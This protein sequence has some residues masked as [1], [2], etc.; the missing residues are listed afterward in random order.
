MDIA[1]RAPSRAKKTVAAGAVAAVA[2]LGLGATAWRST[3][4]ALPSIDKSTVW[5]ERVRRGDLVRQVPVQGTLVPER[6]QWLSAVT[7][8]RVAHIE[9]RPGAVVEADSVVMVLENAELELAALVAEQQAASAETALVQLD[10]RTLAD[11]K[12][13]EGVVAGARMDARDADAHAMA[14]DRLAP[15]GLLGAI[16]HDAAQNRAKGLNE[17]LLTEDARRAVLE[18]GRGRQLTA[19]RAEVERLREIAKFRKKQLADLVIRAGVKGVVQDVPLENGQWVA[20]GALL[21]KVAEPD[22]LKADVRVAEGNAREVLKGQAVRFE[23]PAGS[24][25]G[26]IARV[27]PAVV[28][29]NVRLEVALDEPLPA[30]ARADQ[31]VTGYVEIETLH[32]ALFVPRP[33]AAQDGAPAGVFVLDADR[34]TATRRT[35]RLGRGSARDV[36]I[37]GGL[38][39][40]DE[41]VVSDT[42]SWEASERVR[43]K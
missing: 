1:R 22:H 32:D 21:A 23:A 9:L 8:A 5:T 6:V 29:G 38:A 36:E 34:S 4:P 43:L 15:Q 33:A 10:V 41:I 18:T 3:A 40:G 13:Q 17:R 39:E 2:L 42:S 16:D 19:Q 25:R 14:A 37:L 11:Q 27:D 12:L 20:I 28:A 31:A 35:A 30:G 26:R 24:F 7:A